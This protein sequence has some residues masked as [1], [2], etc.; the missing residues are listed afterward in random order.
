MKAFLLGAL[1]AVVGIVCL[2]QAL[3]PRRVHEEVLMNTAPQPYVLGVSPGR[4]LERAAQAVAQSAPDCRGVER[5][6]HVSVPVEL[7]AEQQEA[8]W[9]KKR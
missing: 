6:G 5:K 3:D 4:R 7:M 1:S 8:M 2:R 9:G